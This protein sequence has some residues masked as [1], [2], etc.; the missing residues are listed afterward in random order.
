MKPR[1]LMYGESVCVISPINCLRVS[2]RVNSLYRRQKA[3]DTIPPVPTPRTYKK[4]GKTYRK[5]HHRTL[6]NLYTFVKARP[7]QGL[8]DILWGYDKSYNF[9]V[10]VNLGYLNMTGNT[11]VRRLGIKKCTY[12][13]LTPPHIPVWPAV[14]LLPF[15]HGSTWVT[16]K[17]TK[18]RD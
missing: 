9:E 2:L 18:S 12:F 4:K 11:E 7:Y 1:A 17:Y 16:C 10:R 6:Q 3:V 8:K 5:V 13:S 14:F 15:S